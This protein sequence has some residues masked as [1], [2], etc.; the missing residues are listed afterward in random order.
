VKQL[1]FNKY[2]DEFFTEDVSENGEI[3][4]TI[5]KYWDMNSEK[6]I[7]ILNYD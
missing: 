6:F 3:R 2:N 7:S 1:V 5:V 4:I